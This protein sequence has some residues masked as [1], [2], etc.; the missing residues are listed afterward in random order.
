[1]R[2]NSSLS[3]IELDREARTNRV[4]CR[5][6]VNGH[7]RLQPDKGN[8]RGQVSPAPRR[9]E[10]EI[11]GPRT[12]RSEMA[13]PPSSP[14]G[15]SCRHQRRNCIPNIEHVSRPSNLPEPRVCH[16]RAYLRHAICLVIYSTPD[17]YSSRFHSVQSEIHPRKPWSNGGRADRPATITAVWRTADA[18]VN[19]PT[20]RGANPSTAV[21]CL[22]CGLLSPACLD[23]SGSGRCASC[24]SLVQSHTI[25]TVATCAMETGVCAACAGQKRRWPKPTG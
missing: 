19:C 22:H 10:L 18:F 6:R 8:V 11:I 17:S 2:M 12:S 1:L 7:A 16:V 4:S 24:Q 9:S 14:S 21:S 5:W 23:C 13:S 20:C 25:G 3:R 15:Y